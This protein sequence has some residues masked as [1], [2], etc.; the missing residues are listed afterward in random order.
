MIKAVIFDF[1]GTLVDSEWAYAQTDKVFIQRYGGSVELDNHDK[2]VGIGVI[3]F[4][5]L[6]IRHLNIRDKSVEELVRENDDIYLELAENRVT[7]YPHMQELL[8]KLKALE[9]PMAVAS[10]SS[11]RVI[12]TIAEQ[13]SLT[14]YFSEICSSEIVKKGKPAPDVFLYVA[15]KM[16]LSPHECLVLEDSRAGAESAKAAGMPYVWIDETG[17]GDAELK[18]EAALYYQAGHRDFKVI[19]VLEL[20]ARTSR[21]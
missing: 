20:V 8:E 11:L 3:G 16:G 4:V 9:I 12:E 19:D 18:K 17:S 15:E 1:D 2:F 13:N 6:M 21:S 7:T 5:E 14:P 10:G